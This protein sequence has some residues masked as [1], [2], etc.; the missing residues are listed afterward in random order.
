MSHARARRAIEAI[1]APWAEARPIEV[2]FGA[3]PFTPPEGEIYLRAFLLPA[4]TLSRFLG[5]EA[6]E[7]TGVYQVSIVV[8]IGRPAAEPEQLVDELA[9]LLAVDMALSNSGFEGLV[10][11]PVH[12]GPSIVD[13]TTYTVPTSFTYQG[14]ADK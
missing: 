1:L 11:T 8:P 12:P 5:G 4:S 14:E 3:E 2:A 6:Y 7:Y 10:L 13:T 9:A